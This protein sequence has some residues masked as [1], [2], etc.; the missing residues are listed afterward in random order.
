MATLLDDDME[1]LTLLDFF[2]RYR[3]AF[4]VRWHRDNRWQAS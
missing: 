1:D 3:E 4:C 2:R